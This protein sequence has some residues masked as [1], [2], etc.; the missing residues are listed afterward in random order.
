MNKLFIIMIILA[1]SPAPQ[2]DNDQFSLFTNKRNISSVD[3]IN[4]SA[5]QERRV[6]AVVSLFENAVLNPVYEY[7]KDI[8]DGRGFTAGKVG[9]TTGTGDLLAV[10]KEYLKINPNADSKWFKLLPILIERAELMSA[11]TS[12]LESLPKLWKETCLDPLFIQSQNTIASIDYQIPAK[13]RL[14]EFGLHSALAYLI[15]DDTMV[16]H[17]DDTPEAFEETDP[18]GF[19][20]IIKS[21]KYKPINE[22]DFLILFLESRRQV[23]L[24]S[25]DLATRVAWK[26]SVTRIDALLDLISQNAWTLEGDVTVNIWNSKFK[27]P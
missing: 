27:L 9:F 5:I 10:V 13:N 25:K 23:L 3:D 17:G 11:S 7:I 2:L 20:G 8:K 24:N 19:S 14:K 26:E 12:G 21:M 18:D 6:E 15:F 1:F 4:F 16:Q 22:K